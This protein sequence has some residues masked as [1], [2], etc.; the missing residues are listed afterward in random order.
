MLPGLVPSICITDSSVTV[1]FNVFLA[2]YQTVSIT[3]S[4]TFRYCLVE[5]RTRFYSPNAKRFLSLLPHYSVD[6]NSFP[7]ACS[8]ISRVS[9]KRVD[10]EVYV[11][12]VNQNSR[13]AHAYIVSRLHFFRG[14]RRPSNWRVVLTVRHH[15]LSMHPSDEPNFTS[16][17]N[18]YNATVM[19][20]I[21]RQDSPF[22]EWMELLT[23]ATAARR[24]YA[25]T[26]CLLQENTHT[27]QKQHN[28]YRQPR[29]N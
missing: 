26:P 3:V 13:T 4:T 12:C 24:R 5:A 22:D 27:E 6:R 25:S 8:H 23:P 17:N 9:N 28:T 7:K 16:I 15:T 20:S 14:R 19:R 21:T 18:T 10:A 11:L 2:L 1:Y 29:T